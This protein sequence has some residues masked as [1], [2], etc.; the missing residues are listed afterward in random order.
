MEEV[1][2]NEEIILFSENEEIPCSKA[3][4]QIYR[5][6]G[7]YIPNWHLEI[8][9]DSD[10]SELLAIRDGIEIMRHQF[11]K[12]VDLTLRNN[13]DDGLEDCYSG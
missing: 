8:S 2:W 5:I 6:Q 1:E 10:I 3:V 7:G 11:D 12:L 9:N 4:L 13:E